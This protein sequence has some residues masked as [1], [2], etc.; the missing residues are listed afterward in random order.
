MKINLYDSREEQVAWMQQS[1]G[2][3]YLKMDR[4]GHDR[5]YIR[6]INHINDG[7]EYQLT[8]LPEHGN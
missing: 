8:M 7:V 1:D 6:I 5:A 4:D 3:Q 2:T